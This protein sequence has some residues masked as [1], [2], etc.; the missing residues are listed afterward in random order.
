MRIFFLYTLRNLWARRLTT[1]L[2]VSGIALVVGAFTS[3]LMLSHGV[4]MT[5]VDT[6]TDGNLIC[7]RKAA[8]AEI[9]SQIDRDAVHTIMSYPEV[10]MAAD[11]KPLASTDMN[12]IINLHKIVGGDMGNVTIRGVTPQSLQLRPQV[13]IREGRMVAFGTNEIIVGANIHK[14]FE[15]CGIGQ[16]LKFGNQQW[17]IVGVFDA[18]K[19]GF[20]SEVWCDVNPLLA[21]FNRTVFSTLSFRVT[22]E[23]DLQKVR[24][25]IEHDPRVNYVE[26]KT[27]KAFYREQSEFMAGFIKFLGSAVVVIFSLGAMIGAMITMYAAVA[28]RTVEIGTIRALGFRRRSILVAFLGESLLI[29]LFGYAVGLFLASWMSF[30]DISTINFGSFTELAFSFVLS[31][32]IALSAAIFA[33]VM[34]VVGGFLPAWRASRK[35]I[36]EALRAA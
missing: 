34:G 33:L 8:N 11:G 3:V 24:D 16:L 32:S 20:E 18:D 25:R 2:T 27:E 12:T 6:G 15:E 36:V 5:L 22:S 1:A 29:S 35:N 4:E 9:S 31:P 21:A 10:Q 7:L 28:N 13:H 26:V 17:R 14:R 30:V 23:G 19:T